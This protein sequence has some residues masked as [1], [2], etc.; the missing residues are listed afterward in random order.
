MNSKTDYPTR[1][2]LLLGFLKGSKL[3]FFISMC[4]AAMCAALDLFMPKIIAFTVD[5]ILIGSSY[6]IPAILDKLIAFAGGIAYIRDHMYLIAIL[7]CVVA[8]LRMLTSY[9]FK[10]LNSVSEERLVC[11]ARDTL[12]AHIIRLPM[13]WHNANRTGDIIQRCTSDLDTLRNFLAEQVTNLVRT[14]ILITLAIIFMLRVNVTLTLVAL[15]LLPIIVGYS[16]Y[17]HVKIG[18][19]FEHVDEMEGRLSAM[20]QEN[21]TGVRVVRAFGRE[22][23]E[24]EHFC[25][26]NEKYMNTWIGLM[27]LLSSF[28]ATGDFTGG[29][30]ALL[31]VVIGAVLC[32]KGNISAGEYI[33]FISYNAMLTWPVRALGRVVADMSKAGISIDRIR[34]IMNS[35]EES[36]DPG[37]QTPPMNKDIVFEHVSFRY[38][39]SDVLNDV[40]FTIQPG[41]TVGILGGTGSGKSTLMHL[42]DRL[43][44]PDKDGGRIT[45]G[46]IDIRKID[47]AWLR[48]NIG[49]VLQEPYLFSGTIAENIAITRDEVNMEE[50]RAAA[51]IAALD[52]TV[53]KFN[54]GYD[55]YVGERGVTLSGGQKQRTAIAQMIMKDAP[56]MIFDDSL[57][58]VD[59]QTDAM[60]RS[61]LA[62][63]SS[64]T[65]KI[66]ISHRISTLM[67]ADH[68]IV[69][70]HGNLV[71]QGTHEELSEVSGLYRKIYELQQ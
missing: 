61:E 41:E 27:K 36:D 24:R 37:A 21:L 40:S 16:L 42:L 70:D 71:Q 50:V 45:I 46:G 63:L 13:S 15:A 69:M 3:I 29:F 4:F 44:E 39:E 11:R 34:Y 33:E 38:E 47:R 31:I 5:S 7:I 2:S 25:D 59:S 35:P 1:A 10:F 57:S 8:L 62:S 6:E 51:R 48:R 65:T 17:F 19:S 26:Y 9:L 49:I 14:V 30:Q 12:Y 54:K 66:I 64:D 20:V 28:W 67:H 68:I 58:A 55:T 22:A 23:Y 60:I 32:V 56:I 52:E 53:S 18:A 43:Y